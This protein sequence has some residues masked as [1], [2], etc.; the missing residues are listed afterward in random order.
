MTVANSNWSIHILGEILFYQIFYILM[1]TLA[2]SIILKSGT[3]CHVKIERIEYQNTFA[4]FPNDPHQIQINS[5]TS[6]VW[7]DENLVDQED[8]VKQLLSGE[9]TEETDHKLMMLK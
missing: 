3:P 7:Q 9:K 2:S 4:S 5:L 1:A 6:L 8:V